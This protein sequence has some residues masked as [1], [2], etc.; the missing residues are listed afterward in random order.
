MLGFG[1]AK[2]KARLAAEAQKREEVLG[3]SVEM[4]TSENKVH[5]AVLGFKVE[6]EQVRLALEAQALPI[7][8]FVNI[9]IS[10]NF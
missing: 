8:S 10:Q 2:E 1:N 3:P 7:A 5:V 4:F 6:K 9:N